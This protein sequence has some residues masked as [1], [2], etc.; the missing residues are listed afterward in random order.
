MISTEQL[1]INWGRSLVSLRVW[2][3]RLFCDIDESAN[4]MHVSANV[5]WLDVITDVV[6]FTSVEALS[7][8]IVAK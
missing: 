1:N 5:F 8:I 6:S 3:C 7:F 4:S 2:G